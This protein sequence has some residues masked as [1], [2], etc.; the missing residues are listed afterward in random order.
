MRVESSVD[1]HIEVKVFR[2]PMCES[3]HRVV[4]VV[5][6]PSGQP[7][8]TA[9]DPALRAFWRSSAKPFQALPVVNAALQ[10]GVPLSGPEISVIC[11][12]HAA[13]PGHVSQVRAILDRFDIP[14]EALRCG[15]HPPMHAESARELAARGEEPRPIHCNCSGK[16][17]GMLV[18]A[19]LMG[20]PL[21]GYLSREHPVQRAIAAAVAAMTGVPEPEL[22]WGVDGCGAPVM[23]LSVQAMAT[24][25]ARLA[26]PEAAGAYA[27]A[28]VH[29][30]QAMQAHPFYVSGTGRI[31][32]RL[33]ETLAPAVVAKGG[34][35]GVYCVG[36]PELKLGVALKVVDGAARATESSITEVLNALG[37]IEPRQR[38][39]LEPF[40]RPVVRNNAG[41]PVGHM[42]ASLP[43][44]FRQALAACG[45]S[46]ASASSASASPTS[47]SPA[48]APPAPP[49]ASGERGQQCG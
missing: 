11:A 7:V 49:A 45:A 31:C 14:E 28:A 48:P 46:S 39:A 2:G 6:T 40:F 34:A 32:T 42:E 43:E 20:A 24:A 10:Q 23:G 33:M 30:V 21:E 38:A 41:E 3:R 26:S 15:A 22:I 19:R 47:A 37:V 18:L 29:V 25:F 8:A 4:A 1:T 44:G 9:G 35:E 13:E 17:A 16:H 12:S 5:T 36:L 27:D